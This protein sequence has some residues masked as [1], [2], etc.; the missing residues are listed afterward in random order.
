MTPTLDRFWMWAGNSFM[1]GVAGRNLTLMLA[2]AFAYAA[3]FSESIQARLVGATAA[4]LKFGYAVPGAVVALAIL[5]PM[6]VGRSRRDRR[7]RPRR[8]A[9]DHTIVGLVYAYMLRFF[10]VA[11]GGVEASMQRITP[12]LDFAARTLGASRLQ[13]FWR[14]HVPLLRRAPWWPGCWC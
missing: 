14:V 12:N 5:W 13:V 9:A 4:G 10:A 1:A 2:I 6:A 3:R 7:P 8:A 11:Y